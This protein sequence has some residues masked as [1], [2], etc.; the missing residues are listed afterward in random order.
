MP[1]AVVAPA[2]AGF[3]LL[4][5]TVVLCRPRLVAAAISLL[6]LGYL[7]SRFG[8]PVDGGAVWYGAVLLVVAELAFWSLEL[9]FTPGGPPGGSRTRGM[10]IAAVTSASVVLGGVVLLTGASSQ[11]GVGWEVT[12]TLAAV[13]VLGLVVTL[14]RAVQ[15]PGN[16]AP[17]AS[18]AATRLT[19][20]R[21]RPRNPAGGRG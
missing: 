10:F 2:L 16:G 15:R 18:A 19:R 11:G 9:R 1:A 8:Q 20:C 4:V 13:G 5:A 3:T 12:G 21:P 6:G 17:P 14:A 7:V